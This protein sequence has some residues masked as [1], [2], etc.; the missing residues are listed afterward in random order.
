MMSGLDEV[1][2]GRVFGVPSTELSEEDAREMLAQCR[3][4]SPAAAS[5][6]DV[7]WEIKA[8]Y[9]RRCS[10]ARG[11][12]EEEEDDDDGDDAD[13]DPDPVTTGERGSLDVNWRFPV[14]GGV[15]LPSCAH[16]AGALAAL[17][18]RDARRDHGATDSKYR[19]L[20]EVEALET[21]LDATDGTRWAWDYSASR[22]LVPSPLRIRKAW[23]SA[24]VLYTQGT[25]D[26]AVSPQDAACIQTPGR[27]RRKDKGACASTPLQRKRAAPSPI[28]YEARRSSWFGRLRSKMAA[29]HRVP[30]QSGVAVEN[31][32]STGDGTE[33]KARQ[34]SA[35][36]GLK[37]RFSSLG[38]IRGHLAKFRKT[39]SS[40]D[41]HIHIKSPSISNPV[42]VELRAALQDLRDDMAEYTFEDEFREAIRYSIIDSASRGHSVEV[43]RAELVG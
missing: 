24:A 3:F 6:E 28:P 9:H 13:P 42:T 20:Q 37:K 40:P 17:E 32:S 14:M 16:N 35:S 19:R 2:N 25:G 34:D 26:D 29:T 1:L 4:A 7:P 36:H 33:E 43:E 5:C 12:E 41:A 10:R 23:S 31:R 18:G 15:Q 30:V 38:D 27:A 8:Y 21:E 39:D 22:D 11:W